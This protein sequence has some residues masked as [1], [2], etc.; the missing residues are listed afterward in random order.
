[1]I[2]KKL[3]GTKVC[4]CESCGKYTTHNLFNREDKSYRCTICGHIKR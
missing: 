1:M 2:K 4:K 3:T